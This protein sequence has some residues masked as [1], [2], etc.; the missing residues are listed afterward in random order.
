MEKCCD[1]G[2]QRESNSG[3]NGVKGF[4]PDW[5]KV[6]VTTCLP[7]I[8]PSKLA[9]SALTHAWKGSKNNTTR[10]SYGIVK[11]KVGFALN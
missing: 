3:G 9:E 5:E 4:D 2:E 1:C 7:W 6:D 10:L 8:N 11:S